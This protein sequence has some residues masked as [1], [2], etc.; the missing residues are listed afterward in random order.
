MTKL[1]GISNKEKGKLFDNTRCSWQ[2]SSQAKNVYINH[3][4]AAAN[5]ISV[6]FRYPPL[7]D[8]KKHNQKMNQARVFFVRRC[9]QMFCKNKIDTNSLV[10]HGGT[11]SIISR[12]SMK[13]EI[14]RITSALEAELNRPINQSRG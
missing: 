14:D 4:T 13:N 12:Q 5:Y 6:F 8:R 11:D 3:G 1:S 7:F 2:V 10:N 9:T